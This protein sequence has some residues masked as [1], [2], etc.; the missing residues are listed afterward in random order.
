MRITR[1]AEKINLNH[2]VDDSIDVPKERLYFYFEVAGHGYS[3]ECS[4]R[5][6]V[7]VKKLQELKSHI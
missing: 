1:R 7:I 6:T 4:N 3:D 2:V 5:T